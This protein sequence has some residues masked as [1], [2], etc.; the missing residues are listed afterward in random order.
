MSLHPRPA[1]ITRPI[2][3]PAG[4]SDSEPP[5]AVVGQLVSVTLNP[6]TIVTIFGVRFV[7]FQ[8]RHTF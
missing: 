2:N 5:P 6:N 8:L 1:I 7:H 3:L 4:P